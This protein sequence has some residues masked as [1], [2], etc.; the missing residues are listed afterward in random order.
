MNVTS[1]MKQ[2]IRKTAKVWAGTVVAEQLL[3]GPLS[4]RIA[5]QWNAIMQLVSESTILN[6]E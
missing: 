4:F 2:T 1:Q 6:H 3:L 5:S